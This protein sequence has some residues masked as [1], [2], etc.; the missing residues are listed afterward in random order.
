VD[1]APRPRGWAAPRQPRSL[2]GNRIDSL[3]RLAVLYELP[4]ANLGGTEKHLLTLLS[5]LRSDVVPCLLAPEGNALRLFRDLGVPYRT[6][7]PLNLGPGM[8]HALRVHHAAFKELL[9]EFKPCLVHVHAGVELAVAARLACPRIPL[10]HTIHGY[11]DAASYI[12]SAPIANRLIEEVICVSEAEKR[13]A[14]RHGFRKDR[15]TVIHNGVVAPAT[16][17]RSGGR[18]F[19]RHLSVR[20]NVVVVGTV[21]RLERRKG[22]AHLVSAFARVRGECPGVRLLVVGDGRMRQDLERLAGDLGV[23][24]LV[25]FTGALED[26]SDA[27]ESMDVFVLPSL[28]EAL[29]IAILEAMARAKPV[30]A[31]TVGG[32]PEAVAHGET[33]LLVPPGDDA[34][35]ASAIIALVR[36]PEQRREMGARGRARFEALFTANL[37]ARRTLE[38]YRR[39]LARASVGPRVTRSPRRA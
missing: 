37:M 36:S 7:V 31:T 28:Q 26:P 16:A 4:F 15:L 39:V 34:A 1:E 29:G 6:I 20:E 9:E 23:G 25:A 35:L 5:S 33:G 3:G 19:R 30:I 32:I 38:V 8:R 24:E 2:E 13:A 11:P 27:L 22:L 21:S 10:V 14:Q 12:V 18:E 17:A